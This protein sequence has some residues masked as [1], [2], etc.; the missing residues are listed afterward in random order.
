MPIFAPLKLLLSSLLPAPT[1]LAAG[2]AAASAGLVAATACAGGAEE[3]EED[4]GNEVLTSLTIM[5]PTS[6]TS[7]PMYGS[8]WASPGESFS[9]E[10]RLEPSPST[11][12]AL[13][14]EP[15]KEKSP[16]SA[17][18]IGSKIEAI[19]LITYF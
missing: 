4:G 13:G 8:V 17:T 5:V 6:S 15:L 10:D 1:P 11:G 18:D 16:D 14:G 2:E 7:C 9:G 12:H 3:G 19:R